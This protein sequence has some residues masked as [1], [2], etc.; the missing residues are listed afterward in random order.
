MG[1]GR[2]GLHGRSGG[3]WVGGVG[4]GVVGCDRGGGGGGTIVGMGG[5]RISREKWRNGR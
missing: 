1:T 5:R 2:V 3:G 4:W